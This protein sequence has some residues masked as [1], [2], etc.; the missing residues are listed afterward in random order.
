MIIMSLATVYKY[1]YIK[2]FVNNSR[3]YVIIMNSKDVYGLKY[4]L[5]RITFQNV[6]E[7]TNK[8]K[9]KFIIKCPPEKLGVIAHLLKGRKYELW[10]PTDN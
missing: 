4:D 1:S 9:S 8:E 6:E 3:E 2:H 5:K 7:I 10:E